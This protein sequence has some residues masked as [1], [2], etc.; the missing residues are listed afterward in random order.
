MPAIEVLIVGAGPSGLVLALWLARRGVSLRIVDRTPAPGT[1]SR[2][3]AVHARTLEFYRQLG[4]ADDVVAAGIEIAAIT[5]RKGA[6]VFGRGRF[7]KIGGD[8]SPY[9][10]I[11][12]FPQ[13]DHERILLDHLARAGVHVERS[14]ELREFTDV[15]TH[16]RA[17]LHGPRGPETLDVAWL[18]GADGAHSTVRHGLGIGFPGGTYDQVFYVAD[19]DATG[20]A[21]GDGMQMGMSGH[22]FCLVF[23]IRSSG[24]SRLIGIVPPEHAHKPAITID[25][26]RP[27]VTRDTG[28]TV[29]RVHWFATYHVH[30]RVADAFRR[31]R[32]FLLGDAGHIHS[33]AGGQGMNT[34]IG[35]AVNLAWK[36]ADVIQGRADE[37][38]LATYEPERIAFARVLIRSTDRVFKVVTGRS[39]LGWLWRSGVVPRM[40]LIVLRFRATLRLVFKTVSQTM[41]R[42]R[43]STLSS[44]RAGKLHGGDRMPW[45]AAT[46]NYAPLRSL[47]WQ[48]HVHG[49]ATPALRAAAEHHRLALHVFPWTADAEA[50]GLHRDAAYLLRPDGHVALADP[51]QDPARLAAHLATIT[52]NPTSSPAA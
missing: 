51:T 43:D 47:D 30:H 45:V 40:S 8:L 32:V 48:L 41:I 13:D 18:C 22:G 20:D 14:T 50:A 19:V 49:D 46:N 17:T 21:A 37:A 5:M 25:D 31:G 11:L 10:Y 34:G 3:M 4:V 38:L 1:T 29:D 28:L 36:L 15:G 35:D 52:V 2:A 24:H 6:R 39:W 16:V 12:S 33:P 42:Y 7:G 23:P 26:I 44:G 27:A 9:P